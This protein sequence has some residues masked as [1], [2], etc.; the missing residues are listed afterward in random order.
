MQEPGAA[1]LF[2]SGIIAKEAEVEF[3]EDPTLQVIQADM[4]TVEPHDHSTLIY[5]IDEE[6]FCGLLVHVR[7]KDWSQF[8][9]SSTNVG[10]RHDEL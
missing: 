7:S 1:V 8:C 3:E 5:E 9:S 4:A 10:S 6:K 2:D